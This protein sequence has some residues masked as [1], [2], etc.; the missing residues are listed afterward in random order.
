MRKSGL[1]GSIH[2]IS[3]YI[4]RRST[5]NRCLISMMCEGSLE[6][7]DLPTPSKPAYQASLLLRRQHTALVMWLIRYSYCLVICY[8]VIIDCWKFC[9]VAY[10]HNAVTMAQVSKQDLL[11]SKFAGS[12]MIR[13]RRGK[14]LCY[15]YP[16]LLRR[17]F[18]QLDTRFEPNT[19][20]K[21]YY[22][23]I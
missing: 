23:H 10:H 21:K 18:P 12:L 1:L 22:K 4:I 5:P 2:G 20:V 19:P 16:I 17:S 7:L 14:D 9:T 3:T 13:F 11:T 8:E 6:K 15:S